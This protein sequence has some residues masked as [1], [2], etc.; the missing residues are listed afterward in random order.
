VQFGVTLPQFGPLAAGPGVAERIARVAVTADRLGYDVLW[1]AE[2]IVFPHDIR[3]PY[4][5]GGRFPFPVTDPM[6]EVVSTLSYVAALTERIRLS[7]SVMI[8][9]Y[10]NPIVLAKE[11]ATLDVLSG[12]RLMVGVASGWLAEEFRLLG[13]PFRERGARMDEYLDVLRVLWTEDPVTFH[14]RFVQL[15]DAAFFPKP[16]QKPHPP[17]WIGGA[18]ERALERVVRLGAGW[19]AAPRPDFAALATDVAR[20]RRLAAVRGRDPG[21]IGVASGGGARTV[22]DLLARLPDLARVGVTLASVPVV[23]WARSFAHA[24]ELLEEF[25]AKAGLPATGERARIP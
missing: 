4:P 7:C 20:L 13:V 14:G 21:T 10:R 3:T 23:F 5:Y 1:T 2:H 6:L 25:A 8:L 18:S 22:D 15:D 17:I 11:L 12:G 19:I 24:L 16:L 9:P